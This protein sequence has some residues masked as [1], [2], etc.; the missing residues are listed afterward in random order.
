MKAY[1]LKITIKDSHPPIWRRLIVPA[2]LSF[3]QLSLIL[4]TTMGWSGYHMSNYTFGQLKVELDDDFD[5]ENVF[6]YLD[7]EVLDAAN[8]IIDEYLD[9]VKTFTYTYDFGDDWRHQIKVEKIITD[10]EFRYP[11]V[12]K[13]KGQTPFEDCGGI[14]GYYELLDTLAHPESPDYEETKAWT[15]AQFVE[16]YDLDFINSQLKLMKLT[17]RKSKPMTRSELYERYFSGKNSFTTIVPVEES[18][19]RNK[20]DLSEELSEEIINTFNPLADFINIIRVEIVQKLV[21]NTSLSEEEILDAMELTKA[22]K[23]LLKELLGKLNSS[24]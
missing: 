23:K 15:E 1:Q 8:H 19:I 20:N 11:Q 21:K 3:S 2:G 7:F 22:E 4:N 24:L 6:E 14:W 17:N 9:E 10:Y 12:I 5:E 13:Y 16:E 18:R